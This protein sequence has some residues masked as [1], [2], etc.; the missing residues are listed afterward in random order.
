MFSE[1]KKKI[2]MSPAEN[3]TQSAKL[4]I[5]LFSLLHLFFGGGGGGGL[6]GW[7]EGAGFTALSKYFT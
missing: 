1:K 7:L 4:A 3:F 2:S 5:D 6:G